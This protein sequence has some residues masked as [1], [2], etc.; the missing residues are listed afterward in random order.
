MTLKKILYTSK[1][2]R[3][4]LSP[5]VTIYNPDDT[6]VVTDG[7]MTE[8][9]NGD[10]YYEYTPTSTGWF[11]WQ[12][13]ATSDINDPNYS[14]QSGVF[15][16]STTATTGTP[17][18]STLQLARFMHIEGKVPDLT[19]VGEDRTKETV[20][21]GDGTTTVY[22]LDR[23][24]ILADSYTIYYGTSETTTATLTETTHYEIDKDMGKITLTT[25]GLTAL[26]NISTSSYYNIYA[27]YSYVKL[28]HN[29]I[30]TDSQLSDAISKAQAEFETLTNNHFVDGTNETPDYSQVTTEKHTGKGR[31]DRDYYLRNFP[32]PDVSATLST[33][34]TSDGTTLTVDS[35]DGFP[36]SGILSIE[37][38]KITYTGKS[39][40][41]FTGLVR[42]VDDS[43][44]AEHGT[45]EV[46]YPY[47]IEIS[48]ISPGSLPTW[49]VLE[50]DVDYDIQLNTGKVH[51]Y[52]DDIV[53]DE[54]SSTT[55]PPPLVPNRF[56]VTYI[57]G[58]STLSED[59]KRCVLMMASKDLIHMSNRK[60]L[61][62]G[63]SPEKGATIDIDQ[64]EIDRIVESYL[65]VNSSNI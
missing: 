50:R 52:R 15:Y 9:A 39:T 42:G 10:Y 59:I 38:E 62:D 61:L 40:T 5:T 18:V 36:S 51:I 63:V 22:Y 45:S 47:V 8:L 27:A 31:F 23:S 30:L 65:N 6:A 53:L 57:W 64:E 60:A 56:R 44:E 24:S 28:S 20:G 19:I 17:F 55:Y 34:L 58:N 25:S 12:A 48:T 26:Y 29:F 37:T 7:A 1:R 46:T 35:T 33:G 41:T 32:L 54:L 13:N 4:G 16:N 3:T 2:R 49:N 14:P 43:T 11:V 21:T